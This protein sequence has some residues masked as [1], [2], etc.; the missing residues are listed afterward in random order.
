MTALGNGLNGPLALKHA[1]P[2]THQ[3][4][5]IAF[6]MITPAHPQTLTASLYLVLV[7]KIPFAMLLL[8]ERYHLITRFTG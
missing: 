4:L 5:N 8:V 7:Q 6:A 2:E 1:I 3:E